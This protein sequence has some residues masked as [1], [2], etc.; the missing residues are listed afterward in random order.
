[1]KTVFVFI[2]ATIIVYLTNAKTLRGM[3][4]AQPTAA[5]PLKQLTMAADKIESRFEKAAT[6]PNFGKDLNGDLVNNVKSDSEQFW[7]TVKGL[8]PADTANFSQEDASNLQTVVQQVAQMDD[9]INN[10]KREDKVKG[11]YSKI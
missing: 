1:M 7:N 11:E 4:D 2:L 3:L 9:D 10:P 8:K 5:D 6:N